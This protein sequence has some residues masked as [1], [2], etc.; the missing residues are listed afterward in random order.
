MAL[1]YRETDSSAS[2][3][4]V[5][6]KPS[7]DQ[8]Q[9]TKARWTKY[10]DNAIFGLLV[11][12]AIALPHS[13]KGAERSWKIALVLWL[14]KLLIDRARPDKQPLALPLLFYVFL[15][16]I[17]TV[18]SPEPYLSWDRMKFVCLFMAGIVVAQNVKRVSQVRWL[19]FLL[20]LSGFA[21][22]VYT[23]WQYSF[24]LGVRLTEF[25]IPSR[26]TNVGFLPNDIITSFGGRSVHTPEQLVRAVNETPPAARVAVEY[27]RGMG[28]H[29]ISQLMATPQDFL[30]SGIDTPAMKLDRGKPVRAQGT[31]GH[32]VVFAEMLMQ[33][34][35][36]A[37]AL[38]L[39]MEG[40]AVSWKGVFAIAF[41][42]IVAAIF[43]T[44]TRAAVAGLVLGCFLSLVLL[45]GRRTRILAI[46]ALMLIVAGA[47]I[48]IQHT[49]QTKWVDP[50]D[51]S[52]QFRV[53]MWEDGLRL[54]RQHPW[55]GIGM[56]TVRVH[57]REWNVRAFIQYNVMSH[58]HSTYLQIAVERG[59][60][61]LVA[62]IW[63]SIAYG[64]FLWRLIPRLRAQSRFAGAVAVG[65][66]AG[67]AA[68][69]FTSF[70]HY[71]LGEESLAM[72]F[73]FYFGLAV[74]MDRILNLP[75]AMDE[76]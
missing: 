7:E 44:G 1:P 67:L 71:N 16:A 20:V 22:V 62:W 25:P 56:E 42:G 51:I 13:I 70:F 14:L 21:S 27:M 38:L 45:A 59:M 4:I 57:Y 75:G 65:A 18:L 48:W 43:A 23:G 39:G 34:G 35:C 63:F 52:T 10:L 74:A 68:F 47:T 40:R 24:G 6:G 17:S 8:G 53:L 33:V 54:V 46:A 15:S 69:S 12:F 31:L 36:M 60:P 49:R 30:R 61:A 73:F 50:T 3:L 29:N 41:A 76:P 11:V 55:F 32:Y 37:W 72:V 58:F 9:V 5:T 28:F 64:V 66:L 26:L 2:H 19:V